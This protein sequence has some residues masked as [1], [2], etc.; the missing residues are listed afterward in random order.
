M[1]GTWWSGNCKGGEAL[2]RIVFLS[3]EVKPFAKTGGLADVLHA[4]PLAL[5]RRGHD[6]RIIM[7][8]YRC[9]DPER[10]RL[11]PFLPEILVSF[12][13]RLIRGSVRQAEMPAS[14]LPVYFI[15]RPAFFERPEL[16]GEGGQDYPDN[17]LRFGFYCAA[18]LTTLR[19]MDWQ[20]DVIH[21]NDWQTGLVPLML[22]RTPLFAGDAFFQY[23]KTLYSVHNLG[24]LGVFQPQVLSLLGLPGDVNHAECME[25]WGGISFM[26]SGLFFADHVTTVSPTYAREILTREYGCGLEGYLLH[27]GIRPEGIL[28]GVDYGEWDPAT[29]SHL[30]QTYS[31]E[32][33]AGK[34]AC[35]KDLQ[36]EAGL[37]P[38]PAAPLIGAVGRLDPQKGV[39]LTLKILPHLLEAGCQFVMLGDDNPAYRKCIDKLTA[40]WPGRFHARLHFDSRF[41]HLI[42]AGADIFPMP[43][44]YEPCGLNQMFSMKYGTVPVV[45]ETGGLADTVIE[46]T[47][48]AV[49]QGR[50]TGFT[51]QEFT[52]PA[53]ERAMLRALDIYRRHPKQWKRIQLNGMQ[54]NFSWDRSAEAYEKVYGDLFTENISG[55]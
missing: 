6:V 46:A 33:L 14:D 42:E 44:R 8:R 17:A 21:C 10:F 13:G 28:N 52:A 50:G 38:D 48:E 37:E 30:A 47:P 20:P 40:D 32:N 23:T 22:K 39:D 19:S 4:L 26:K 7:P 11:R 2:L 41:A 53:M 49:G 51:F 3:S 36:Q 1:T 27:L 9:V 25:Y 35:K 31:P 12:P 15:E 5:A 55:V 43:S 18:A 54:Q 29:D 24:Y 45:R 16:Y 34:Q